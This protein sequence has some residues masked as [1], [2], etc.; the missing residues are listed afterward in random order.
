MAAVATQTLYDWLLFLHVLAAM[1]WLGSGVMLAATAARAVRDPDP[2]AVR[3]FTGTMRS[4]APFV[5]APSTLA[6]LGFGIGLVIDTDRGTSTSSGCGSA[7]RS[8]WR[9]S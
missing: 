2:G 3:R 7:S 1:V 8:S 5:L 6:V 9:R 4:T